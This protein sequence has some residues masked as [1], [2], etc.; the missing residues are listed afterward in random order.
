M[1]RRLFVRIEVSA[2][3]DAIGEVQ[4]PFTRAAGIDPT[5]P[6]RAHVTLKFVGDTATDRVPEIREAVERAV[7]E[8]DVG[9]FEARL[10]GLGVFPEFE[11]ID[12]VWIGVPRGATEMT[13]LHDALEDRTTAI[14]VDPTDHEFTPH[15]TI[16]RMRHAGGKERVQELVAERDP[17]VG[18]VSVEAVELTESH[19]TGDG[20]TYEVLDRIALE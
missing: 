18:T 10:G 20:P 14:G 1:A 11:Y 5:D 17:D 4:A 8:A 3:A 2:L 16:G 9:P 13:R 6:D 19:L 15:V 12:V 7:R